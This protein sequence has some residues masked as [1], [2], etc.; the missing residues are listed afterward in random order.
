MP[1][2]SFAITNA[3]EGSPHIGQTAAAATAAGDSAVAPPAAGS[4]VVRLV[5]AGRVPDGLLV[6]TAFGEAA[7]TLSSTAAGSS[8]RFCS[9]AGG[10]SSTTTGSSSRSSKLLRV[11]AVPS[12]PG[13]PVA[14]ELAGALFRGGTSTDLFSSSPIKHGSGLVGSPPAT[15]SHGLI[16]SARGTAGAA[17]ADLSDMRQIDAQQQSDM[18]HVAAAVMDFEERK[19]QREWQLRK[20]MSGGGGTHTGTGGGVGA[21]VI[22][23]DGDGGTGGKLQHSG[24]GGVGSVGDGGAFR[25]MQGGSADVKRQLLVDVE[26]SRARRKGLFIRWVVLN[27]RGSWFPVSF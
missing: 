27:W 14:R 5:N 12:E 16:G 10:S 1:L 20:M 7:A 21:Y 6:G 3:E 22:R 9:G 15:C 4:L 19:V 24:A 13:S 17:F 25:A 18:Q 26:A 23:A 8:G 2:F 11:W